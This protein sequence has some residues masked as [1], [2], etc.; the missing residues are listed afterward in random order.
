MLLTSRD[1]GTLKD[2]RDLRSYNE[3]N[4]KSCKCS[5]I[6]M[7]CTPNILSYLQNIGAIDFFSIIL[8]A[9]IISLLLLGLWLRWRWKN[10]Q[11][12]HSESTV[13]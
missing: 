12:G 4:I 7:D 3:I 9:F 1:I 13:V 5:S 11:F 8:L 2:N 10:A 6:G